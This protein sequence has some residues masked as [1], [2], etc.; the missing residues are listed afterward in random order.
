[1]HNKA[2]IEFGKI[3]RGTL[4][5]RDHP[6]YEDARKLYNGMIDKRPLMIARCADVADVIKGVNFGGD[7]ELL[8]AIRGGGHCFVSSPGCCTKPARR[9]R[10]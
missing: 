2:M 4:I 6:A 3:L 9:V 7:N 8:I 5:E 10:S 1:M